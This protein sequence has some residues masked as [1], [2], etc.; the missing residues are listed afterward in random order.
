MTRRILVTDGETRAALACARSLG[1][2]GF[3][4][5]VASSVPDGLAAASRHTRASHR[6]ADPAAD[7]AAWADALVGLAK[8]LDCDWVLPLS[9]ISLGTIYAFGLTR[10]CRILCPDEQPYAA[11][12]DKAALLERAVELGVPT[13]H[14]VQVDDPRS[15]TALPHGLAYPVVAKS[16]W[17]RLYA[18]GRWS[19]G[20]V[21]TLRSDADLRR[22]AHDVAFAGGALIQEYVPGHGEA[23]FLLADRGVPLVECAHRRLREK[24]PSGGQSVLRESIAPDPELLDAA[25]RLVDSLGWHGVAMVEFRR[26][27]DG[28]AALMEINPR[29]WG[30]LQLAI[31]AGVDFPTL[32]VA[33][34]DGEPVARV[35]ARVGV[36][37]RWL[38]GDLDHLLI[39]LRRRSVREQLG[40]SVGAL[41]ADFARSF[42]DGSRSEVWR[43]DDWRPFAAE[44]RGRLR[45]G[46]G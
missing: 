10:Q 3:E 25:R 8:S 31:D 37:T 14:S 13:P 26:A 19:E 32:L 38:L 18:D 12:V 41:L 29:F 34:H 36:R 15:L 7:P 5:H 46:R 4:V 24:P 17:S 6:V 22:A 42:F 23:I 43:R 21:A 11:A 33:L 35:E 30:S 1:A 2:H 40:R 27:R 45:A 16:R 39:C 9:E 44:L 20:G 28:R